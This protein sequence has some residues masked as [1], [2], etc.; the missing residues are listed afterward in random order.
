MTSQGSAHGR[1]A[2]A[3]R[4]KN[5][6]Q[7]ELALREM[8]TPNLAVALEYLVLLAELKPEKAQLAALRWH[9]RLELEA[10]IM[11]STSPGSPYRRW[12]C[13]S[14]ETARSCRSWS[15]FY[16]VFNRSRCRASRD[17]GPAVTRRLQPFPPPWRSTRI[18]T[19]RMADPPGPRP[20][21]ADG[22]PA[23]PAGA[24][25]LPGRSRRAQG[26]DRRSILDSCRSTTC[27]CQRAKDG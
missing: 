6:F 14:R 24:T 8:G 15:G 25:A 7:A 9:G 4:S 11:T 23:A 1:F 12:R 3:L 19:S 22:D 16:D 5:L 18:V 13:L 10:R 20:W 27:R 26:E 17:G 2:R 21:N